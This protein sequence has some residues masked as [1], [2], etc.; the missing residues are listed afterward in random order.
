MTATQTENPIPWSKSIAKRLHLGFPFTRLAAEVTVLPIRTVPIILSIL[1]HY[2][3]VGCVIRVQHHNDPKSAMTMVASSWLQSAASFALIVANRSIVSNKPPLYRCI[4]NMATE[5]LEK[6]RKQELRKVIRSLLK[7]L[8]ND[9]LAQQSSRVWAQVFKLPQYEQAGSIG[10]FLSMPEG[11]IRTHDLLVDAARRGKQIYVPHVGQNFEQADMEL[12]KVPLERT[13]EHNSDNKKRNDQPV[14]YHE[15]PRNRWH[16]PEPPNALVG[17]MIP[18]EPGDLDLI[19][20]P[21]LA[22]DRKGNRLGQGKGYY[23]R[24]LH[25]MHLSASSASSRST[26]QTTN[27]KTT[28]MAVGLSCQLVESVPTEQTDQTMDI[29]VVPEAT[30]YVHVE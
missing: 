25:R 20:I 9:D 16:I 17:S 15:W 26:A 14:F 19:I 27:A 29:I 2:R 8:S 10:V 12:L 11:E 7:Q 18:A 28:L 3:L 22:F 6:S 24:F 5:N 21:G 4:A 30:I 23:D 13:Q 1:V